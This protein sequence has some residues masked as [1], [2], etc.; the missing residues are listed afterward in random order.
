MKKSFKELIKKADKEGVKLSDKNWADLMGMS[1]NGTYEEEDFQYW[2]Y[3]AVD[4]LCCLRREAEEEFQ[5]A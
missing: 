5:L 3:K 1:E 2:V 4:E